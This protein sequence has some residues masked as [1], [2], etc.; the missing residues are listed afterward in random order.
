[1]LHFSTQIFFKPARSPFIQAVHI[2][3]YMLQGLGHSD[4]FIVIITQLNITIM[5][6]QTYLINV[7]VWTCP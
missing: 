4:I 1:M 6:G 2:G 5:L 3:R 7:K